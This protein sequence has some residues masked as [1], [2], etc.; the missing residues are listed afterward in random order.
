MAGH[1]K[2]IPSATGGLAF[3]RLQSDE[4]RTI[5]VKRIHVSPALDSMLGAIPGGLHDPALGA[6]QTLDAK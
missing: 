2:P 3:S 4:I 1:V 6:I 5:S